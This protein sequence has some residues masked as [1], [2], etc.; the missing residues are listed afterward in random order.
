M[1]DDIENDLH[2]PLAID[3]QVIYEFGRMHASRGAPQRP[4]P[5]LICGALDQL[6]GKEISENTLQNAEAFNA[7][8]VFGNAE[9]ETKRLL[10]RLKRG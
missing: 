5:F 3:K 2:P 4:N 7:G 1:D 10:K 8:W 9:R 6:E